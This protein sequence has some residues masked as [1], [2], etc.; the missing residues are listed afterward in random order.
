MLKKKQKSKALLA[1]EKAFF[2]S[3][4]GQLALTGDSLLLFQF[5]EENFKQ[6]ARKYSAHEHKYPS[7]IPMKIL[8]KLDY[9]SS[10]PALVTFATHFVEGTKRIEKA[11]HV[12]SP[13]VC[14]HT[15]HFLNTRKLSD[16]PYVVTAVGS[17]FRFEGKRL[18]DTPE[19]L[20]D[21]TMREIVFLGTHKEVDTLRNSLMKDVA[22]FAKGLNLE[23]S[24]K[25]A[26]D[27]F[28]LGTAKG[29]LLIQKFKKL[30]YELCM[31]VNGSELAISSFNNHEDFFGKKVQ[32]TLGDGSTAHTGC[33]AFGLERWVYAFYSAHG[34]EKNKWPENVRRYIKKYEISE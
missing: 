34:F 5:F 26:T 1:K 19:R 8:E 30:K 2:V 10:F 14:Y 13:A 9:F 28:F 6:I 7:L 22:K 18:K 23:Y 33:V 17:C 29:K 3:G 15:Y 12:L 4:R 31:V 27:P 21:F 20:W 11:D 25:E 16:S 32:I 24:L